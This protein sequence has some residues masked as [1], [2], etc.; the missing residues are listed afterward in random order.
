MSEHSNPESENREF[1]RTTVKFLVLYKVHAPVT[2]RLQVGDKLI[3]AIAVDLSA[4]GM[5]V[6]TNYAIP[7]DT[8]VNLDFTLLNEQ[9]TVDEHRCRTIQIQGQIRYSYLTK[10]KAYRLGIRFLD[11]SSDERNFIIKFVAL[12]AIHT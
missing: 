3:D 7:V 1:Q 10:E 12:A 6:L 9:E 8:V 5:A 2:V 11:M 4:G